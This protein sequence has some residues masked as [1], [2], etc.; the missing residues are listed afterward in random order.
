MRKLAVAAV[1][2]LLLV[3]PHAVRAQQES[4]VDPFLRPAPLNARDSGFTLALRLG[5]GIPFGDTSANASGAAAP[6]GDQLQ[7]EIP[8][9]IDVGY[10]FARSW[11]VGAYLQLGIGIVNKDK[12]AGGNLCNQPGVSCKG[13]DVRL[14][15]EGTY[16][17]SPG[18]S[19]NPWIG[20]GTGYEWVSLQGESSTG[21]GEF[22]FKGWEYFTL[23]VGGDFSLSRVF[24]LGP[25]ASFGLGQYSSSNVTLGSTTFSGDVANMK[26]HAWLQLGVKGTLN[27]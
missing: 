2:S 10:R 17:F 16:S 13:S 8:I 24:A 21:N 6:L 27:L 3:V 1:L 23:Q 26:A 9:W 7:G 18:Q 4:G 25:Y 5:Y 19:F 11:F 15:V 12:A 14:G 20:L 22:T